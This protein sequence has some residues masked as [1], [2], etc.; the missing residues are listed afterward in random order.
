MK[1]KTTAELHKEISALKGEIEKLREEC[2]TLRKEEMRTASL[3]ALWKRSALRYQGIAA[4]LA[5]AYNPHLSLNAESASRAM[6]D[7]HSIA[8]AG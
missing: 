6:S 7:S 5:H 8:L 1:K 2:S 4:A 3:C